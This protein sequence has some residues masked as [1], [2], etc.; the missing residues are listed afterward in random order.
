MNKYDDL[1]LKTLYEEIQLD[2]INWEDF[3]TSKNM[4]SD[5]VLLWEKVEKIVDGVQSSDGIKDQYE[6]TLNNGQTFTVDIDFLTPKKSNDT[7]ISNQQSN[8]KSGTPNEA[9]NLYNTHLSDLT[10]SDRICYVSFKDSR[11]RQST[12]GEVGL[13]SKELFSG[14]KSSLLDSLWGNSQ[15]HK[16]L[17]AICIKAQG[18]DVSR[19]SLFSKMMSRYLKDTFPNIIM[20]YESDK[21][22]VLIVATK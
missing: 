15:N 9:Y 16:H 22:Y 2:T 17:R 12:T 14:L 6:I 7:I 13:S 10:S 1:M 11:G 19:V 18:Q 20:D 21:P 3:F 8:N 4:G 5:S